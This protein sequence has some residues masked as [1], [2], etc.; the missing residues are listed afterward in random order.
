MFFI[1]MKDEGRNISAV[2]RVKR[3]NTAG[4]I[5]RYVDEV[6]VIENELWKL[7]HIL[8]MMIFKSLIWEI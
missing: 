4:F 3:N 1:N 2:C 7:F 8:T 6:E 5:W